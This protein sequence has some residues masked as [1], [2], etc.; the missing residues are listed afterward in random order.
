MIREEQSVTSA[1]N[2]EL[3]WL[4]ER[5]VDRTPGAAHVVVVGQRTVFTWPVPRACHVSVESNSP[6]WCPALPV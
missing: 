3:S 6:P 1:S 2:E 4:L 5:F